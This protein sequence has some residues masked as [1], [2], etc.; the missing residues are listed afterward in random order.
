[1][2]GVGCG[3]SGQ[4]GKEPVEVL[5]RVDFAVEAGT[6]EGIVSGGES[7]QGRGLG[8]VA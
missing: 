6:D 3:D 4:L 2:S 8:C 1:M 5:A 7:L